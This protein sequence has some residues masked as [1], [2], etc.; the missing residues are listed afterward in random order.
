MN[1]REI[2]IKVNISLILRYQFCSEKL[3]Q[4]PTEDQVKQFIRKKQNE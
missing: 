1:S 2:K 4:T 3:F